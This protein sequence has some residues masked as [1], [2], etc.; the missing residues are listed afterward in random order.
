MASLVSPVLLQLMALTSIMAIAWCI[1][2]ATRNSGWIDATWTLGVGG[3]GVVSA[4]WAGTPGPADGISWRQLLVAGLVTVWAVRL[5][6]HIIVRSAARPD[7]PRYAAL[8]RD[9]GDT[10]PRQLFVLLQKQAVVSLPLTLSIYIAA[11]NPSTMLQI[12][13]FLAVAIGVVAI[14]GEALADRQLRAHIQ[15]S[16]ARNEVCRT[17][18]WR[19]SRHPNYFFEWLYWCAYPL[20]A[21][22]MSGDY[23]IAVLALTAPATMYWL[24]RYVSGVP[25]LEEHMLKKYGNRYRTYQTT[26]SAFF[27]SPCK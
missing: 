27:P 11:N 14:S 22:N 23:A 19:Y 18:L 2:R 5:G 17:G 13:D 8:M 20:A 10:A 6:G 1:Q 3:T 24:L 25:P 21:I 12:S 4:L 7:D 16:G 26:T 15:N 9:W